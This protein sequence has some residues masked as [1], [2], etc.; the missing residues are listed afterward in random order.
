MTPKETIDAKQDIEFTV[1]DITYKITNVPCEIIVED[2]EVLLD[3]DITL[4]VALLRDLMI[5]GGKL[6]LC[7]YRDIADIDVSDLI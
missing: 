4:R 2:D 7:D 6:T 1:N 5:T 3:Y